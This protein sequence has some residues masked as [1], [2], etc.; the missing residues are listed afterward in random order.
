MK[1]KSAKGAARREFLK[2][3]GL[4]TVAAGAATALAGRDAD[5]ATPVATGDAKGAGYQETELVQR[6]YELARF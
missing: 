5:A 2:L 4:G 1:E 6:Y 3:A